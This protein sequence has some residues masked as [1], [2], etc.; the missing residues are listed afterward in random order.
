[1]NELNYNFIK[2]QIEAYYK[3]KIYIEEYIREEERKQ[4][5][6]SI[7]RIFDN[8]KID[9]LCIIYLN[10]IK[11]LKY[12]IDEMEQDKKT[13]CILILEDDN[14][15][16]KMTHHEKENNT[17]IYQEDSYAIYQEN[18]SY[19]T[20][21]INFSTLKQN[22]FEIDNI[23]LLDMVD[24]STR[25]YYQKKY[26]LYKQNGNTNI[27]KMN[28][29]I[30]LEGENSFCSRIDTINNLVNLVSDKIKN[31]L[32]EILLEERVKEYH[33]SRKQES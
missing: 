4:R 12:Q 5:L 26:Y 23:L 15:I 13:E 33:I 18:T 14:P 20:S 2:N 10:N 7:L 30:Y 29:Q 3:N 17:S 28:N 21:K 27:L 32:E 6:E 22:D 8:T 31:R 24:H 1:M 9:N 25:E 16:F 11:I 19:L